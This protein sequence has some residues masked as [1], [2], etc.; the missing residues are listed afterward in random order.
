MKREADTLEQETGSNYLYL[1]L[2]ALVHPKK[3]GGEA[4]APLFLLP[5]RI[6]GGLASRPFTIALDGQEIA[7]P[8]LCL[9]QW[10]K[11]THGLDLPAL[12]EPAIDDA[13]IAIQTVFAGIREGAG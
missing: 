12:A 5:I 10:L 4:R 1:T 2:G 11:T 8:N 3:T 7:Q 6:G 13:G 9:L